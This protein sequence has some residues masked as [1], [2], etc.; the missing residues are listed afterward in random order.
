[1]SVMIYKE[2]YKQA[3]NGNAEAQC[4]LGSNY[5]RGFFVP[6]KSDEKAAYWT[7]K[8]A[9]QGHAR[10]KGLCY[11]FGYGVEKSDDKAVEWYKKAIVQGDAKAQR[12]LG[13]HYMRGKG[14]EQ[15]DEK[16]VELFTKAVENGDI[17]ARACLAKF[18]DIFPSPEVALLYY[19]EEC[20]RD[21]VNKYIAEVDDYK[22][23]FLRKLEIL[24]ERLELKLMK[25]DEYKKVVEFIQQFID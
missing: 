2:L 16:A 23:Y 8:A 15:S 24:K 13:V 19:M 20:D 25:E 7:I 5:R 21:K 10:A 18:Y 11:E 17:S 1:M 3:K 4:E 6:E 22:N 12:I 14:V 9:E